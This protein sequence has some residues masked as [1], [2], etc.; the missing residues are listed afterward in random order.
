MGETD[1]GLS[2]ALPLVLV[3][4]APLLNSPKRERFILTWSCLLDAVL[5]SQAKGAWST[6]G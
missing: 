4:A 2:V 6:S 1:G 3:M 5:L